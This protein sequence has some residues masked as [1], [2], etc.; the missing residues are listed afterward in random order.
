LEPISRELQYYQSTDGRIP[1]QEWLWALDDNKTQSVIDTRLSRL[2]LGNF[3]SCSPVGEGVLELKI[4][5]GPGYRAY[6]G[7]IERRVVLL[8]TGGDK[9]T[10][11]KDIRLAKEFWS[12]YKRRTL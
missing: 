6:F 1:F 5:F 4:D 8:L 11:S 9:S 10:Q 12:D 3:G 7:Q 2:R